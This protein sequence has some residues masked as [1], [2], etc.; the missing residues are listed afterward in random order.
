MVFGLGLSILMG[1]FLLGVT[2]HFCGKVCLIQL[3]HL[4]FILSKGQRL[5]ILHTAPSLNRFLTTELPFNYT[6]S[7][8]HLVT[9]VP[10]HLV[11]AL[12]RDRKPVT[13]S[14]TVPDVRNQTFLYVFG[15]S[16]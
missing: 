16:K 2:P 11:A 7:K 9:L 15:K 3:S 8:M 14:Q 1:I 10:G 13:N 5:Q 12:L 4:H 6:D